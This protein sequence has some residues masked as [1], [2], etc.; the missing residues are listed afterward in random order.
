VAR[1]LEERHEAM[2]RRA[3]ALAE[4]VIDQNQIWVRRFGIP[5]SDPLA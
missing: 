5:P 4:Q 3:R 1:G 2:Q